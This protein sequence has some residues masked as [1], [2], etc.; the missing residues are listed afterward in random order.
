MQETLLVRAGSTWALYPQPFFGAINATGDVKTLFRLTDVI[1]PF[2]QLMNG[3]RR[4]FVEDNA[5][6]DRV[7]P[8]RLGAD[9]ELDRR[10]RQ[11]RRR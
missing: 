4:D 8:G 9:R 10:A 3:C 7:L 6:R 5:R 2:V 1:E 11:P